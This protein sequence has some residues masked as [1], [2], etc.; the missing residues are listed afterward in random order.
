[1]EGGIIRYPFFLMTIYDIL[2]DIICDK[3]EMLH[4]DKDFKKV[5]QR[6]MVIRYLS[7]DTRYE[8]L[9][10][11]LNQLSKNKYISDDDLYIYLSRKIPK[12]KNYYIDY[13]AKP[14]VKKEADT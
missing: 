10:I 2:K 9:A 4:Y 14:K 5:F 11:E 3:T 7:M 6:F 8:D 1:M 13:I 12:S